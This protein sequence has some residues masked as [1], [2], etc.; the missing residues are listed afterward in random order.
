MCTKLDWDSKIEMRVGANCFTPSPQ[1]NSCLVKM[2]RVNPP[3]NSKLTKLLIRQAFEQRRKKLRNTLSKAP[4]RISR[5]SGWHA[6]AYKDAIQSIESPLFDERPE[7]LNLDDW[8]ELSSL[9]ENA[10][11]AMG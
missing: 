6:K 3:E 1:V 4:K 9:L 8:L 2:E 10:R 7:E 11:K 5:V